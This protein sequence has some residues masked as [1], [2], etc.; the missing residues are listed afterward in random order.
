MI[1]DT[2]AVL[3]ILEKEPERPEFIDLIER[4]SR[5]RMSA[6]SVLEAA[7]VLEG[8][9]GEDSGFDLDQFLRSTAVEIVPFDQDQLALARIGFRRYGKGHHRARL[10]FGDCVAYAL[11]K[12]TGEPL[13]F[14]GLDFAA[15]DV[16]NARV[17]LS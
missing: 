8:R 4:S 5:I 12:A 6:V 14:K 17:R 9:Y 11:S 3:A 1:L 13:L 2:S 10:N 7:M 15:T 16:A